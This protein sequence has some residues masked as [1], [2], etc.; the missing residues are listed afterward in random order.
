MAIQVKKGKKKR[1][2]TMTEKEYKDYIYKK[3]EEVKTKEDLD[4]LLD[5]VINCKELDYGKIVY[6]MSACMKATLNYINRS[7]VGGITGFQAGFIGWEMV[8][9]YLVSS[10]KCGLKLIN[11]DDMLYPQNKYRYEKTISKDV[12]NALQEQAKKNL[13]DKERDPHPRV[14]KHWKKIAKGKVPFGYKVKEEN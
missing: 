3:A 12:W 2:I 14:L 5:E 13:Q 1:R 11:Y 8:R 10:N 9:E 4:K 6:A 7:N